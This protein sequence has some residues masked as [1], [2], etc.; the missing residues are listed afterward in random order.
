MHVLYRLLNRCQGTAAK[1]KTFVFHRLCGQKQILHRQT[2]VQ[3]A[4]HRRCI[5]LGYLVFKYNGVHLLLLSFTY[6]AEDGGVEPHPCQEKPG[7]Q[8]QSRHQRHCIIFLCFLE[9]R[10]RFELTVFGICNPMRWAT[11][12]PLHDWSV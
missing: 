7:F 1:S 11:P 8:G 6:L 9:Q 4:N 5:V 12:P 10:V 3:I 2:N